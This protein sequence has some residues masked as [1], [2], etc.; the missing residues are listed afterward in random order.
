MKKSLI[1]I[2]FLLSVLVLASCTTN[3]KKTPSSGFIGGKDGVTATLT[4]DSTSGANKVYDNGVDPF[5]INVNLQNKGEHSIEPNDILITLDGIN[6]NAF[7]IRDQTQGNTLPMPGLR[8]EA[9]QITSP[10]QIILQ[11]DANYKPREDADRPVDVSANV[12]YKYK[13]ISRVKDLCLRKRITGPSGNTSCKVDETK[14][15][16]NSGAPFQVKTFNERPASE[17]KVN[18]WIEAQNL[19]KGIVYP[20]DFLSKGKCIDSEADKNKIYI[21]VELTEFET[22]GLVSCGGLS[23]GNEGIIHVIQGKIQLSC[24]IDTSTLQE[25]TFETPLRITLNYVYKDSTATSLT[26]KSS[27]A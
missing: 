1:I 11:Y 16:E 19:G 6:F 17:N 2:I 4:I 26:I 22:K 8:R 21:K 27:S 9:N 12:C 14:L 7:Q 10:S 23:G 3:N 25:T 13:T 18:I 20:Q 5:K 24:N 15:V